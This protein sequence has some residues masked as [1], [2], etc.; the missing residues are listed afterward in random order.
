MLFIRLKRLYNDLDCHETIHT[1]Q[2]GAYDVRRAAAT[3][4][5]NSDA[6]RNENL[7]PQVIIYEEI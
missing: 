2:C 3:A 1:Q 5:V 4:E 6:A 7:P